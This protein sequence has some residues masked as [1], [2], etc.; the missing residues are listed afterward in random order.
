MKKY[1]FVFF[2]CMSLMFIGVNGG[3]CNGE[4]SSDDIQQHKQ[5]QLL[6]QAADQVGMPNILTFREKRLLKLI[7]ENRDQEGF[8]T[9]SYLWNE[10]KGQL[11][12]MGQSIGY[13]IPYSTQYTNPQKVEYHSGNGG[14][15]VLP[16]ADPNALFSPASCNGTWVLMKDPNSDKTLPQ[17]YEPNVISSPFPI[18]GAV[19]LQGNPVAPFLNSTKAEAK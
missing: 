4:P 3:G 18:P 10:M 6:K 9:Y 12:F 8:L 15:A 17:Y 14:Y 13:P 2:A 7:Y 16:Q 1:L 19:D 11:V 5:E